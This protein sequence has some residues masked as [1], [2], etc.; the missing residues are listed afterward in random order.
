MRFSKRRAV[1]QI[2][3]TLM[4]VAI[5]ASVGSA[6]MFQGIDSIQTF[7]THVTSL[8]GFQVDA[9]AEDLIIEHVYMYPNSD[10]IDIHVTNIGSVDVILRNIKIVKIDTQHLVVNEDMSEK[11][12]IQERIPI[13][14]NADLAP[15]GTSDIWSDPDY[16]D[17][18]EYLISVSTT[19][20]S[21]FQKGISPFN[22]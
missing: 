20:G 21:T 11:I 10:Q 22:T 1:S 18:K 7:T 17:N 12:T 19:L 14:I 6:L 3:G 5:V 15:L 8:V 2:I 13:S 16:S 4:M 9:A